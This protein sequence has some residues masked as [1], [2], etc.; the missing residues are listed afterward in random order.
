MSGKS[1]P[2]NRACSIL[3]DGATDWNVTVRSTTG[4]A[5][6]LPWTV[7]RQFAWAWLVLP[8]NVPEVMSLQ[9]RTL[10]PTWRHMCVFA[11]VAPD[12][13]ASL[14]V[15]VPAPSL[16]NVMIRG[17]APGAPVGSSFRL[18]KVRVASGA[19]NG[20]PDGPAL[21]DEAGVDVAGRS[22]SMWA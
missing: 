20:D 1:V 19:G 21:D 3:T 5:A 13:V 9:P 16:R 18:R 6:P 22:A 4:V 15:T 2:S 12:P 8:V 14:A 17:W 10:A 11:G 7:T